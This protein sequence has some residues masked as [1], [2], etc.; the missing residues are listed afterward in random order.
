[1]TRNLVH[2]LNLLSN[3]TELLTGIP[4]CSTKLVK[5]VKQIKSSFTLDLTESIKFEFSAKF[6]Y[7]KL[8]LGHQLVKENHKSCELVNSG[9]SNSPWV[10]I[11]AAQNRHIPAK[12]ISAKW[13]TLVNGHSVFWSVWETQNRSYWRERPMN[14]KCRLYA[15]LQFLCMTIDNQWKKVRIDGLQLI[16]HD[17]KK[18]ILLGLSAIFIRLFLSDTCNLLNVLMMVC[19]VQISGTTV[20]HANLCW[21]EMKIKGIIVIVFILFMN[22]ELTMGNVWILVLW[23]SIWL[24]AL[25]TYQ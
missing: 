6:W 19:K 18:V 7:Y 10:D 3:L 13:K 8:K 9:A 15:F 11:G 16:F 5:R 1:M 2:T 17:P 21:S 25:L 14:S 12:C 22:H 23:G 24:I 4:S 20:K